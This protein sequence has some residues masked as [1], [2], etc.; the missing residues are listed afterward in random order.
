VSYSPPNQL[1]AA[2]THWWTR[3]ACRL[4]D[5][6]MFDGVDEHRHGAK[7][8]IEQALTVCAT[9]P[10]AA[11]CLADAQAHRDSGVRGGMLLEYGKPARMPT[12]K[13]YVTRGPSI[14]P[15]GTEQRARLHY[16][17]GEALCDACRRAWRER[18]RRQQAEYRARSGKTV[19]PVV[20]APSDR[21]ESSK[22]VA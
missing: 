19:R 16:K 7:E 4:E 11:D 3:A 2:E 6:R 10:V 20:H 13:P 9:C 12:D 14:A 18:W 1:A 22:E 5:A 17:A 15:H 21:P 8:R